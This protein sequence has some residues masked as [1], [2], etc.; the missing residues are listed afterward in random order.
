ML[1]CTYL[2]QQI[3][4][5]QNIRKIILGINIYTYESSPP[6]ISTDTLTDKMA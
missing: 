1:S 4:L 6:L 5:G 2:Y 3:I